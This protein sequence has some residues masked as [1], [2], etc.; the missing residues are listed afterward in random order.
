MTFKLQ[1][2]SI[3]KYPHHDDKQVFVLKSDWKFDMFLR[4]SGIFG[5]TEGIPKIG[6]FQVLTEFLSLTAVTARRCN[7]PRAFRCSPENVPCVLC[8]VGVTQFPHDYAACC[9]GTKYRTS[10]KLSVNTIN[11]HQ[12]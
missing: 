6:I 7:M 1:I 12:I 9:L 4:K 8:V 3:R 11:A 2:K 5:R 10:E